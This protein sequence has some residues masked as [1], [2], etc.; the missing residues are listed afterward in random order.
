M[1][2]RRERRGPIRCAHEITLAERIGSETDGTL[3][4]IGHEALG[5]ETAMRSAPGRAGGHF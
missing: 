3:C 1:S 4:A 2:F 5:T